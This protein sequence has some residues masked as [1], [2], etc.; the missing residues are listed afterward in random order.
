MIPPSDRLPQLIENELQRLPLREKPDGLY[1]PVRYILEDGGKRIRPLLTLL[2]CDLYCGDPLRAMPAALAV[3]VFHNF[4]LL[5]DDIMDRAEVR[6][7]RPTVHRK[8]N[9][10]SAILSGDAMVILSYRLLA[11]GAAAD[12]LPELLRVFNQAALEVCQGQQYDMDFEMAQTPASRANY[13]EMI[14]LKT[15]VLLAAALQ[16]GALIGGASP[17]QQASIYA[18]GV[19]LGLAFQIQDDLLDTYGDA[20][21]FGKI[22]GGDIAVGKQTFLHITAL[23]RATPEQREAIEQTGGSFDERF[24]RV[25]SLYDRLEVRQAAEEAIETHFENALSL[26]A[27]CHPDTH[28]LTE[29]ERFARSLLKRTK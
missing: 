15:S 14:R 13:L 25:R 21:T 10:S 1:A 6:R 4:T 8:W 12:Q 24:E 27:Q 19:Q 29:L 28:R 7:G 20:D 5:H 17:A 2:G 22:I 3:E 23:E 9:E 11:E 26:L 16:M 18:F